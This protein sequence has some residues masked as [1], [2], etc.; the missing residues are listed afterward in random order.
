MDLF[1]KKKVKSLELQLAS[2]TI[3]STAN[4]IRLDELTKACKDHDEKLT[5]YFESIYLLNK[6][7]YEVIH[8]EEVYVRGGIVNNVL[9]TGGCLELTYEIEEGVNCTENISVDVL[10]LIKVSKPK[11]TK[12]SKK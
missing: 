9:Y 5:Q 1:N 10:P 6:I 8:D 11:K 7:E 3:K 2:E 4:Q 12:K